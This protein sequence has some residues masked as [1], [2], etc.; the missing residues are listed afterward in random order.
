MKNN[1]VYI[2]LVV[3]LLLLLTSIYYTTA[4]SDS[5]TA[6]DGS[7]FKRIS[8]KEALKLI[9]QNNNNKNFIIIDVRTPEEYQSGHISKARL[10]NF[11]SDSFKKKL[12]KLNKQKKYFIYCRSGNR[13][14]QALRMMKK[15][16]FKEVYELNGGI[17]N[18][19]NYDLPLKI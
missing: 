19:R 3:I 5:Q 6:E 18:W 17:N 14:G 13:S 7:V 4:E 1:K 12:N 11:Y 10:L 8:P 15:M 2:L 16:K 9:K